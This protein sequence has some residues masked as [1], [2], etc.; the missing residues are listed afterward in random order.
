MKMTPVGLIPE[1]WDVA[2][3]KEFGHL[4]SDG[5]NPQQYREKDF[6][7]YSMPAYDD[8]QNPTK[9]KGADMNSNRTQ[10]KGE[11]LLFNKLNVRQKR[12]WYIENAPSNSLCSM[13]FL[14]YSSDKVDLRLL[15]EILLQDSVTKGFESVSRGT[16]NS[17][18]R[19][20]P[21]DFLNFSFALPPL[22]EQHKIADALSGVDDLIRALDEVIEKK[23]QIKEGLMQQL[24]T[25]IQRV[26]GHRSE[27]VQ[28]EIGLVPKEWK[29]AKLN[30]FIE[31]IN[32]GPFGSNLKREHYTLDREV[33]IVQLG[34]VGEDGWND[35]NVKY[36]TF[37]HAKTL[38]RSI[39]P[40]G[41]VII[42]K[43]MPAG[44]A[45]ICPNK[46]PMYIQGSDVIKVKFKSE[47][48]NQFFVY[49]TKTRFYKEQIDSSLQGS[50]R[51]RTNITKIRNIV[52]PLPAVEEQKRIVD[53][54][55]RADAEILSLESHQAKY[56]LIKRGMMQELLTGKTRL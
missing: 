45:I 18:K 10:I 55:S 56:R 28:T 41:S 23:R 1:D 11:V 5:I 21:A 2:T 26:D 48:D 38:K 12:V 27:L 20:A 52:I 22:A 4:L 15:R 44:R 29:L 33:R 9:C 46:D 53:I 49:Y 54:L 17:Q 34:N 47:I 14:A 7:E 8:G 50:T 40:Y 24:L 32:D 37:E 19:I 16:S 3:I 13:E 36:T 43:M 6:V 31:D 25:G 51:A 42:T 30:D 39:I 35:D